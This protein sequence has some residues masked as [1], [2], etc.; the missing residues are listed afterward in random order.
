[1]TPLEQCLT[2]QD[3]LHPRQGLHVERV[4]LKQPSEGRAA[5]GVVPGQ[6]HHPGTT[7]TTSSS[8]VTVGR[9]RAHIYQPSAVICDQ[10]CIAVVQSVNGKWTAFT[11][12][13]SNQRPLTERFT[14]LPHIQPSTHTFMLRRTP[15][16]VTTTQGP[17][18]VR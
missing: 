15:G 1:M 16:Q 3:Y 14:I 7:T 11:L 18:L 2:P 10:T 4:V 13:F 17:G 12:R 8:R 9:P 5:C 6:L